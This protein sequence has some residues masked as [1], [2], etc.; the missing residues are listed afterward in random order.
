VGATRQLQIIHG[1]Y[2]DFFYRACKDEL[3]R[4][5]N[6]KYPQLKLVRIP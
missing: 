4:L 1:M 2:G 3:T 5:G 6:D